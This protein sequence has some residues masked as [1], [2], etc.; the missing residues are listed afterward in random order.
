MRNKPA[1]ALATLIVFVVFC[2]GTGTLS[3]CSVFQISEGET[4]ITGYNF[5]WH[6]PL[7]ATAYVNPRGAKKVALAPG[8]DK[9]AEWTARFGSVTFNGLGREFPFCGMN[10]AGLVVVQAWLGATKYPEVDERPSLSEL[11]WIQY[12]LDTAQTID[13]V[14]ASDRV[15][16]IS[17]NTLAPL[18]FFVSDR[19]GKTAIL[20]FLDGKLAVSSG[21]EMPIRLMVNTPY[22][23]CLSGYD[24]NAP[25][26]AENRFSV[27]ARMLQDWSE[28][29]QS[30][31]RHAIATL[32]ELTRAGTRWSVTFNSATKEIHYRVAGAKEFQTFDADD[33][34]YGCGE[35]DLQ[36]PLADG[37]QNAG[38]GFT[39]YDAA[40]DREQILANGATIPN[41]DVQ[42]W[43]AM[44]DYSRSAGCR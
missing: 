32:D 15:V 24:K 6:M 34:E 21:E 14:I 3:A 25:P 12:Q 20:E 41:S 11:Q 33:L 10:E 22:Q 4:A 28:G 27:G 36:L 40:A 35:T 30:P 44:A 26:E 37:P 7:N 39:A 31:E 1:T 2:S 13:D 43:E 29:S 18:H 8:G 23:Q 19:S 9:P 42:T 5:D 17:K 16:R 38:T